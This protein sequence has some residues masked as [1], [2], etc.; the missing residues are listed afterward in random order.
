MKKKILSLLALVMTAMAA[1][2]IDAPTYSLTKAE[3]AEAH[4]T[5][6][7]KVGENTV[8]A[9]AE[10]DLVIMTITPATG[11]AVDEVTGKW[12]AAVASSRRMQAENQEVDL[13]SDI[14]LT[15]GD[16]DETTGAATYTFTME[17]ANAE[18][19]VT[20]KHR[21]IWDYSVEGDTLIATCQNQSGDCDVVT[22]KTGIALPEEIIYGNNNAAAI[23]LTTFNEKL[24]GE[25]EAELVSISYKGTLL[26]GGAT[27]GPTATVPTLPG[28][29]TVTIKVSAGGNDYPVSKD[30]TLEQ[31]T[32]VGEM[33]VPIDNCI[34]NGQF[35][36]PTV[37]VKDGDKVLTIGTDYLLGFDDNVNAGL[38]IVMVHGVGNYKGT[39]YATFNILDKELTADMI[40]PIADQSYTGQA[41]EPAVVVKDGETVLEEGRDYS[42]TYENNVEVG[43]ATVTVTAWTSGNYRGEV[44]ATFNIVG[45]TGIGAVSS[46][47]KTA[48]KRYDLGGRQAKATSKGVVIVDGK[49]IMVK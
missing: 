35:Q 38:G 10:G 32:M 21:H 26:N 13:V 49:K 22:T 46:A 2:A 42:V 15:A 29:Y 9:A 25:G 4:G 8:T 12:D 48:A 1:S 34:Y 33:I 16:V 3:S 5:I 11:Y 44:K 43:T 23:D 28:D 24:A 20:Y 14:T 37:V 41:I 7:F 45:T 39:T 40:Q 31:K 6:T 17:R 30:F 18:L 27:Y 36:E 47:S 19:S